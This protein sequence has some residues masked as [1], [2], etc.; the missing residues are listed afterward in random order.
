MTPANF[1]RLKRSSKPISQQIDHLCKKIGVK[2]DKQLT[3]TYDDNVLFLL[4]EN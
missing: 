1:L 3:I 2:F 4:T